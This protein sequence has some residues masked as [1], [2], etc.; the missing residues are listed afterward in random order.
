MGQRDRSRRR[1]TPP[2]GGWARAS[3]LREQT[4]A[5]IGRAFAGQ[6]FTSLAID[7][8]DLEEWPNGTGLEQTVHEFEETNRRIA[9]LRKRMQNWGA[10]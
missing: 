10:V 8:P 1:R 9:E 4:V 3:G 2:R 7:L 5:I 6:P